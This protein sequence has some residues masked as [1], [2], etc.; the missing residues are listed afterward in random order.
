VVAELVEDLLHLERRRIGLDQHSGANGALRDAEMVLG[1]HE[2]V[3]PQPC[4]EMALHL[5]QV[6]VGAGATVD[7]GLGAVEEVQPEVEQACRHAFA[8]DEHVLLGEVPAARP[9]HD[10]GG[11]VAQGVVLAL[12]GG[13]LEGAGDRVA[14]VELALDHVLPQRG[15]GVLVVGQPHLGPGVQRVDRHL[16]VGGS[17][18]FG[19]AVAKARRRIGDLPV[20]LPDILGL[21]EETQGAAGRQVVVASHPRTEQ[22][23]PTRLELAVQAGQERPGVVGEDL[24]EP[25]VDRCGDL[26][27][28]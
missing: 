16:R 28:H 17:G 1:E 11:F 3:V 6:E 12:R 2:G 26:D 7:L 4:L 21:L 14:Q 20:A 13:E 23:A 27:A 15:V 18:D 24:V 22:L 8:V 10:R 25:I 19:A 9:D 5:G